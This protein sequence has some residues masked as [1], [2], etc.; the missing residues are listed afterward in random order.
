MRT[1]RGR[2]LIGAAIFALVLVLSTAVPISAVGNL[3]HASERRGESERAH[4]AGARARSHLRDYSIPSLRIARRDPRRGRQI[5][6]GGNG[7]RRVGAGAQARIRVV[8]ATAA[9]KGR[10]TFDVRSLNA[11]RILSATL[12]SGGRVVPIAS[13]PLRSAVR[14]GRVGVRL[15]RRAGKRVAVVSVARA[16]RSTGHRSGRPSAGL[17]RSKLLV[18]MATTPAGRGPSN[19]PGAA[20]PPPASRTRQIGF[21]AFTPNDP[22][23]ARIDGTDALESAIG[24]RVD[25]VLWYQNW[26]GGDWISSVQP[27]IVNAVLD[28]RRTPLIT[29]EPWDP[30]A[31]TNQPRFSLSRIA[32]G[33]FDAYITSWATDL[34]ALGH[35][36]YLRP[37]H[38]MNGNWY[39]WAGSVNGNSPALYVQ[40]WRH[41]HDIFVQ[42]GAGNVRWVWA[43]NNVDVPQTSANRLESLYPGASYVDVLGVDGYNWGTGKPGTAGWQSFSE[44]FS[45]AYDRLK[46]LG[47]QPIWITEVGSAPE[48]G[49]KGAWVRDMYAQA[50]GMRRLKKIVWF[51]ENKERDWRA[52]P[53]PAVAAAFKPGAASRGDSPRSTPSGTA[54]VP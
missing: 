8:R 4:E 39:P 52:A 15:V 31:G 2:R 21:G 12:R 48:G 38:E 34:K 33:D 9:T 5:V 42:Q 50:Q 36:V 1:L 47:P 23:D 35:I 22:Y 43:P 54:Q 41:M 14:S 6:R 17:R 7:K 27:S 3:R 20:V 16:P 44:V 53:S 11:D 25:T 29:W 45:H 10:L 28:S 26:G 13:A 30:A 18:V 51:N 24:R 19:R 32:G 37:M 46:R 49:N 40:A